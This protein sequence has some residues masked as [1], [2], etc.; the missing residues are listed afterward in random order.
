MRLSMTRREGGLHATVG[1]M[2]ATSLNLGLL[3]SPLFDQA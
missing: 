2:A 1:L 3:L